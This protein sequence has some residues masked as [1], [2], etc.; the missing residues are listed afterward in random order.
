[1]LVEVAVDRRDVAER[2]L[3]QLLQ[4]LEL[5][6]ALGLDLAQRVGER[7]DDR[8]GRQR[9]VERLEVGLVEQ[10]AE[11]AVEQ[12]ELLVAGV[13]DDA[14]DVAGDHRLVH[15]RDVDE[16][17]LGRVDVREVGLGVLAPA[18]RSSTRLRSRCSNSA[19]SV[20]RSLR[21]SARASR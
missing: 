7:V 3:V 6:A 4:D 21:S 19:I 18:M 1:V 13:L 5:D 12:R 20:A 10:V 9:I 17:E 2:R 11:P 8:L 14:R 15:R 16:R